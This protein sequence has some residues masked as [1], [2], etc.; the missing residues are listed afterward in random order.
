MAI[1]APPQ[2]AMQK[3]PPEFG[4]QPRY[5][6]KVK[7]YGEDKSFDNVSMVE[8]NTN[9]DLLIYTDE[10]QTFAAYGY[11]AGHWEEY[12][13]MGIIKGGR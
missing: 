13:V 8:V 3:R 4:K 1:E 2:E 9:G 11:T 7:S 12:S 6:I 5:R 10:C